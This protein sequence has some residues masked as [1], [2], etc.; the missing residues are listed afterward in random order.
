MFWYSPED[1]TETVTDELLVETIL[2]YGSMDDVRQLFKVM[3][4]VSISK[5]FF[6]VIN[7]S[8][9]SR[10]NYH[11]LTRNYFTLLFNSY[12]Y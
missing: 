3:G 4:I 9:R 2:N 11:E 10:N 5:I 7:R 8:E 1:K 12:A 6:T